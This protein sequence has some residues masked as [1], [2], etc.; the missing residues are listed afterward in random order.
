MNLSVLL[1]IL[2][3]VYRCFFSTLSS[4]SARNS[5]ESLYTNL[6]IHIGTCK[7]I[8]SFRGQFL[9]PAGEQTA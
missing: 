3:V 8:F 6:S 2:N 9:N 1:F 4:A 7:I 5:A